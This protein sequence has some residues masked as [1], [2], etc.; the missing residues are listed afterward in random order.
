MKKWSNSLCRTSV[1][2]HLV[3]DVKEE[4][5]TIIPPSSYGAISNEIKTK[6]DFKA[7]EKTVKYLKEYISEGLYAAILEE[8]KEIKSDLKWIGTKRGQYVATIN[9]WVQ[10]FYSE[11][12]AQ[13]EFDDVFIGGHTERMVV[14]ITGKIQ[15]EDAFEQL[16]NFVNAQNPPYK[17]F[18]QIELIGQ[19]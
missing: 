10:L 16:M 6:S 11:F 4:C 5:G 13:K 8:Q 7:L 17:L 14:F 2:K 9:D 1:S 12:R 15:G 18:L 3:E 19:H